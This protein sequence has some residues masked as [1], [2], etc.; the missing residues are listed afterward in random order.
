MSNNEEL[1]ARLADAEDSFVER[2]HAGAKSDE[3]RRTIVAFANSVPAE[4]SGVL[5]IG[6]RDDGE[7]QGVDGTDSLQKT[8]DSICSRECYPP[9][10]YK[11]E[12]LRQ[13]DRDIL[14]VVIPSSSTRPHFSGP[15]FVRRGS[16]TIIASEDQFNELV[17]S[18]LSKPAAILKSQGQLVTVV[19]RGK[20]LGSTKILGDPRYRAA[21]EC[22]V[23]GCTA[24]AVRL[25]DLATKEAVAEPLENVT[26]SVD[27]KA[28]RLLLIVQEPPT[29]SGR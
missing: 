4:R 1:L 2:K 29:R 7:V 25:F 20:E 11:C 5:F 19:A 17:V 24:D 16:Q 23:E 22:R 26:L 8:I 15:A 27:E 18:R 28:S 13:G 21:H 12:V 10:R 14:A 3:L 9:V 6:V